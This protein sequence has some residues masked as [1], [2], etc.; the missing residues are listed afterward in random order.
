MNDLDQFA[1]AAMQALIANEGTNAVSTDADLEQISRQAYDLAEFM[2]KESKQRTHN[3]AQYCSLG[4][5]PASQ[6]K[7]RDQDALESWVRRGNK[8]EDYKG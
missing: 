5:I 4:G 2:E 6:P 1:M 7:D 8:A 3:W